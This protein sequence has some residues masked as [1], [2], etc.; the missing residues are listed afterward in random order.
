[1]MW[2][3]LEASVKLPLV[4]RACFERRRKA[5]KAMQHYSKGV[6]YNPIPLK[7]VVMSATLDTGKFSRYFNGCEVIECPGKL[8]PI[9]VFYDKPVRDFGTFL[10]LERNTDI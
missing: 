10:L 2:R 4:K 9:E 6:K 8:F 1:M 7:V 5:D 3:S